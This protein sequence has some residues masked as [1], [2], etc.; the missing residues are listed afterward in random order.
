[1]VMLMNLFL[2]LLRRLLELND[3]NGYPVVV[4]QLMLQWNLFSDF[5]G[6]P[7]AVNQLMLQWNLL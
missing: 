1:M 7:V 5:N 3:L 4:N 6:Y 2:L